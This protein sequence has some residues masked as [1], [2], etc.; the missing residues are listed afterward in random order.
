MSIKDGILIENQREADN[1]KRII[2]RLKD[3]NASW[4]PHQK[5]MSALQ[6]ASH[7]VELHLWL[8]IALERDSFN[9]HTDYVPLKAISFAELQ[10][11]LAK[12][13]ENNINFVYGTDEDF[14]LQTYTLKAGDHVIAALPRI[15]ALRF[16]INNHL[17]HHRGQLSLYLRMLDIPVPGLYGPSADE[18]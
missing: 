5:S 15:G 12:G 2:E 10:D 11:I 18:A 9:F 3:E 1:T 16:I 17:I 4:K 6:L 7:V 14:W 8:K 13:V